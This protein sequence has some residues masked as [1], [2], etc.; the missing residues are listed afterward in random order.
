[1]SWRGLAELR[2][3]VSLIRSTR[4][5]YHLVMDSLAR[6]VRVA[7]PVALLL[8]TAIYVPLKIFDHKGLARIER[9]TEELESLGDGNRVLR[10]ENDSLRRQI[11][12]FHSD[13]GYVEKVARDELGMVSPEEII[14]QFPDE[15][16]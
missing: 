16:P 7:L 1:V 3:D 5:G 14:Y 11:Q 13:P 10:R 9:L 6:F 2:H 12:A 4:A 8:L 15:R